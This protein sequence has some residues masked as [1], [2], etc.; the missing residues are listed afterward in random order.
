MPQTVFNALPARREKTIMA[1]TLPPS[2]D[3]S[4]PLP[5]YERKRTGAAKAPRPRF[6][7]A[8]GA[9][10]GLFAML[11]LAMG[12]LVRGGHAA[13]AL[14]LLT[15][16]LT[17]GM[18]YLL[19]WRCGGRLCGIIAGSLAALSVSFAQ[20]TSQQGSLVALLTVAALFVF[21]ADA[22]LAA[23]ALAGLAMA[24]GADGLLLTVVLFSLTVARS[25]RLLLPCTGAILA[26]FFAGEGIRVF[27]LHAPAAMP[28]LGGTNEVAL[29][30][31][32]PAQALTLW[33][34]VPLCAE[35]TDPARRARWLPCALWAAL[36]LAGTA[37]VHFGGTAP[38]LPALMP[39]VFVL[40]AGGLARLMPTLAGELPA[41]RYGLAALAVVALLG[42]RGQ[43]EWTER[44]RAVPAAETTAVS[45]PQQP[46]PVTEMP[47]QQSLPMT[48]T[49][50]Q[51]PPPMTEAPAQQPAPARQRAPTTEAPAALPQA[52]PPALVVPSRPARR[53]RPAKR[54]PLGGAPVPLSARPIAKKTAPKPAVAL[55][56]LRNGRLVRRSKW[57]VQWDLTHPKTKP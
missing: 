42:L 19:G 26:A 20:T 39:I 29:W 17:A 2:S 11:F 3:P 23:C 32:Q 25:P 50:A 37:L 52:A 53:I 46:P 16:A 41:L 35:L 36:S 18:T 48:E 51:Q 24:A 6:Q 49:P 45:A 54:G 12:T 33:L 5:R 4:S 55:F 22:W 56:A 44:L 21:A 10:A 15:S 1:Q 57:A 47:S 9:L 31:L 30:L 13:L 40:A 43:S 8:D 27:L 14:P 34:L 7:A 38:T 28:T